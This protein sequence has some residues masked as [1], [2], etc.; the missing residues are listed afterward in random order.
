MASFVGFFMAHSSYPYLLKRGVAELRLCLP[1]VD[2]SETPGAKDIRRDGGPSAPLIDCDADG[3]VE[4]RRR[5]GFAAGF[6]EAGIEFDL[7]LS[8]PKD[9]RETVLGMEE[10]FVL[11][12]ERRPSSAAASPAASSIIDGIRRRAG[13]PCK[14][15]GTWLS[16]ISAAAE[17]CSVSLTASS[18]PAPSELSRLRNATLSTDDT[19]SL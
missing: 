1:P 10:R 5:M 12:D 8:S 19:M 16:S 7:R 4:C 9:S 11:R 15:P 18:S 2:L 6:N 14:M 17:S 13:S 3:V